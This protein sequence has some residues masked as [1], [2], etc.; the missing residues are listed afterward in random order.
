MELFNHTGFGSPCFVLV[1]LTAICGRYIFLC[2]CPQRQSWMGTQ[3]WS[4]SVHLSVRRRFPGIWRTRGRNGFKF[5]V[6]VYP[7]LLQKWFDFGH[8]PMIFLRL[9]QPWLREMGKLL[10]FWQ[11]YGESLKWKSSNFVCWCI[12]TTSGTNLILIPACRVSHF[13]RNFDEMGRIRDFW[14]FHG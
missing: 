2:Y 3:C 8:S 1:I 9:A 4:A 10:G 14:T 12:L 11:F 7:D 6:L 5:R 13:W